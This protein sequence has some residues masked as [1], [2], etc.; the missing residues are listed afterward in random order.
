[1]KFIVPVFSDLSSALLL[2]F[3][4]AKLDCIH[5]NLLKIQR[6]CMFMDISFHFQLTDPAVSQWPPVYP[7]SIQVSA[8][9]LY[10]QS[11][12]A[13][14]NILENE[15]VALMLYDFWQEFIGCVEN[16]YM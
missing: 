5:K 16:N 15:M 2:I 14:Q 10:I 1:M 12:Q 8:C 13:R 9:K 7:I 6:I 11:R 3:Y 4:Q